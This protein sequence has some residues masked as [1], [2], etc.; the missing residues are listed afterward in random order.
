MPDESDPLVRYENRA[1]AGPVFIRRRIDS[2][3]PKIRTGLLL[4]IVFMFIMAII[5]FSTPNLADNDGYYHIKMAWL[6]RIEGL[7]PGFPWLP[8]SILDGEN[9]YDHHFLYHVAL[10]PF[11]FGDLRLGAKWSAVVFAALAFLSIWN[12][13]ESQKIR[14]AWLWALALLGV[15][16]AFLFRMSIPRAQSLSLGLLALGLTWMF[17]GRYKHLAVLSFLYVWAYNA[18]PLMFALAAWYCAAIWIME[19]RTEIRPMVWVA[20]GLLAGLIFNPYFPKN[21]IFTYHHLV[22]KMRISDSIRVGN[23]WYPYTTAQLLDNSLPAL[24]AFASGV[25]ALGLSGRRMT[26][27]LATLLFVALQFGVMLFEA[28]RFVEYFPPFALV[29]AAFSW[30]GSLNQ[31]ENPTMQGL[32]KMR[33]QLPAFLLGLLIVTGML[34]AIPAAQNQMA[35]AKPYNLY[36]GA[37]DWLAANTK[38]GE[39]I[40]QTDWDDFPRLFFY[41]T[42]NTYLIGLDPTYLQIYDAHLYNTWAAITRGEVPN[43]SRIIRERFGARFVHTDLR[44]TKFIAQ[45]EKDPD[46]REVYRDGQA[47]L[48]EV[49]EP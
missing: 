11:T 30:N 44:H 17:E 46:L 14:L 25:F 47:I 21:L 19:Q 45:A 12:L 22:E 48:Y 38:A 31:E 29:F 3:P 1:A 18:F 16:E 4:F 28:R 33:F 8:L 27:R 49:I 43:P 26:P 42:H 15:S 37:S 2:M 7:K 32:R 41:N 13:L 6:M 36:A 20:G 39:M 40:F 24:L 23:E 35:A 9:Y 34:K 5:Q 10:I